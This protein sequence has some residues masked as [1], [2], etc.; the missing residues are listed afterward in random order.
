MSL[1]FSQNTLLRSVRIGDQLNCTTIIM[2]QFQLHSDGRILVFYISL[3]LHWSR[4][5]RRLRAKW[6]NQWTAKYGIRFFFCGTF[7]CCRLPFSLL[8][9]RNSNF[10][11][12]LYRSNKFCKRRICHQQ[13]TFLR[14]ENVKNMR[15]ISL[16]LYY[17][18]MFGLTFI[19]SKYKSGITFC[20]CMCVR[21]WYVVYK[22]FFA[23]VF[24]NT[25]YITL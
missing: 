13:K 8:L 16:L 14:S 7:C 15:K 12:L 6:T 5:Q 17:Y 24:T 20:I 18:Y 2:V 23:F 25:T 11:T 19:R 4:R 21:V 1:D 9:H 22:Y 3:A 10:I